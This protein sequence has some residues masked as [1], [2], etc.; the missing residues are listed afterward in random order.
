MSAFV[1]VFV[2][3]F[4]RN[5]HSASHAWCFNYFCCTFTKTI[6]EIIICLSHPRHMEKQMQ[7]NWIILVRWKNRILSCT[8]WTDKW[9]CQIIFHKKWKQNSFKCEWWIISVS[10]KR[11]VYGKQNTL[12]DNEFHCQYVIKQLNCVY[13]KFLI[14]TDD[15][16]LDN[17][18]KLRIDDLHCCYFC[19]FCGPFEMNFPIYSNTLKDQKLSSNRTFF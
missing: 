5:A 6:V 7:M 17:K 2:Q 4:L 14:E 10:W 1:C 11:H 9:M 15:F 13:V 16:L 8:G 19:A 3:A 18:W 12:C